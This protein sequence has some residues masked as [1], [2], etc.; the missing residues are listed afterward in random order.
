MLAISI[1]LSLYACVAIAQ[2]SPAE[3]AS[4]YSLSNHLSLTFPSQTV[5][6]GAG[7]I[8]SSN[9]LVSQNID[10]QSNLQF[11]ADPFPNSAPNKQNPNAS[12]SEPSPIV[13]SVTYP[14]DTFNS[15]GGAQFSNFFNT[16][17]T[18][19]TYQSMLLTYELAFGDNYNFVKGGKLPGLR[20]GPATSAC[21]SGGKQPDGTDC[22]STRLM[23][24][25][26]GLGEVYAYIP[27]PN[28][29]CASS[30]FICNSD[31]FGDS[32]SRG[33][34][35]FTPGEWTRITLLVQLNDPKYA[36]GRLMLYF[37]DLLAINQENIYYRSSTAISSVQ[38]LFFSTFF[39]GNDDSWATPTTQN[40]YFRNFQL[41][42][43]NSPSN[44]T[45]AQ[46]VK[47]FGA[48][49]SL[50]SSIGPWSVL[51]GLFMACA[52]TFM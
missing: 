13:L 44:V 20:G 37:N 3:L 43:G 6:T 12:P 26:N 1:S 4:A 5:D 21:G 42:A 2:Y 36:N 11:V 52:V 50:K 51:T 48:A 24:R 35:S 18:G 7:F 33:V 31:S 8:T 34:I 16:T 22:F 27:T 19:G 29:I 9:W 28:N 32:I 10:G 25:T 38:G 15:S 23:W 49:P 30:N 40:T 14:A 17:A 45:G 41:F 39:G 47:S 46:Q